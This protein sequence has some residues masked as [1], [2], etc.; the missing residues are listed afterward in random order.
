MLR[1]WPVSLKQRRARGN[2]YSGCRQQLDHAET[3]S[4]D[5][6]NSGVWPSS[7]SAGLIS[8][9]PTKP[10]K[11]GLMVGQAAPGPPETLP[12]GYAPFDGQPG[13]RLAKL[14]GYASTDELWTDFDRIDLV[15]SVPVRKFRLP[16]HFPDGGYRKHNWD[17][18]VFP[19]TKA[20]AAARKLLRSGRLTRD[21]VMVVL[22]GKKVAAAFGLEVVGRVQPYADEIHGG[23]FLV[24]PHPSG[25]SH[26]WNDS[27]FWPRTAGFF[28]AYLKA[29][30]PFLPVDS[31]AAA[32]NT[33][34]EAERALGNKKVSKLAGSAKRFDVVRQAVSQREEALLGKD[35]EVCGVAMRPV[36]PRLGLEPVTRSRFF[37]G[38]SPS[39]VTL[40]TSEREPS[41]AR[42]PSSRV[43][44]GIVRRRRKRKT[45]TSEIAV[46][47]CQP[48]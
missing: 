6:P 31:R 44:G 1:K 28:R 37:S 47:K 48:S 32:L 36:R 3:T 45:H 33:E 29:A 10:R 34:A 43:D 9:G 13:M 30:R 24:L 2:V 35:G 16:H 19:R 11:I 20:M 7:G 25:V 26:L 15:E 22:C 21:Y 46:R 4:S 40:D 14:G 42:P 23:L 27:V 38:C 41:E 17:G 5:C 18:H 12:P 8:I 39:I